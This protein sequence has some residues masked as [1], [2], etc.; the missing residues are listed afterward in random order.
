MDVWFAYIVYPFLFIGLYFEVFLVLTLFDRESRRRR[1][2][3]APESF[4]TVSIIVPCYNEEKTVAATADSVLA[5]EYPKDKLSVILVDDGS[6][7]ATPEIM[8]RYAGNPQVTVIHQKNGG[9]Y[10]ALN[11]GIVAATSEFVGC[12]DADSFVEPGALKLVMPHFDSDKV[13]A[14]TASMSVNQP[15]NMLEKMQEAEYLLGIAMR[16]TLAVWNGLYVT[17]GPF[18]IYRKRVFAEIGAFRPAHDTEDMEIAMRMQR[19]G[20]KIGNAPAAG[21]YTN[22]PKT[23]RALVKQRVRWTTGFLRNSFDYRDL[24]GNPSYGVLGILVMPLAVVFAFAGVGLF[25]LSAFRLG[26]TAWNFIRHISE[27]P[28]SYTFAPHL[29]DWFYVPVSTLLFISGATIGITI[30]L[31]FVGA[32]LAR[33]KTDFGFSIVWYFIVY[34]LIATWWRARSLFD[35]FFGVKRS[36]R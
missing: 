1:A 19:H 35:V 3:K 30:A 2:M 29:P 12:L 10:T 23:V 36:W 4:P 24:I 8:D 21:V 26:D 6:T 22:A 13:G 33:K 31:I 20:W 15:N 25:V 5:L 32:A 28:L 17:P 9:K 34:T 16:H 11:A 27:V 14:V 7:D 18:T